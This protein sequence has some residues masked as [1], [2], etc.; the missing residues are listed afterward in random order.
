MHYQLASHQE[1]KL[2]RCIRGAVYDVIIDLRPD[3]PT[4]KQWVGVELSG[5][6]RNMLYV[7]E[8]FAHGYQSL[9]DDTEVFYQVSQFYA[10]EFE[11]GVRYDDPAFGIKWPMEARVIS[12]RDRSWPNFFD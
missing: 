7:P 11:A 9:E 6:L 12:A 8:N 4:Y 3:S 5:D 10:P 2:V 1:A